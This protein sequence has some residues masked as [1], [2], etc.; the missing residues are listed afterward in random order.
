M[1]KTVVQI[2]VS[3]FK[4]KKMRSFFIALINFV[5]LMILTA[6]TA[7]AQSNGAALENI[8][9]TID[10]LASEPPMTGMH[11]SQAPVFE[12]H[13][14]ITVQTSLSELADIQRKLA[15][16]LGIQLIYFDLQFDSTGLASVQVGARAPEQ[17]Y[18]VVTLKPSSGDDLGVYAFRYQNRHCF[19]IGRRAAWRSQL[20]NGIVS[21]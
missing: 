16:K 11:S 3:Q 17:S 4:P 21:R 8:I 2:N 20:N 6:Q 7:A 9:S 1:N 18:P 5:C 19:Y 13:E 10:R 14:T 15:R 12:F